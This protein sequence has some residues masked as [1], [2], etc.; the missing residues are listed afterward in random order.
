MKM[1]FSYGM[2]SACNYEI[3][4]ISYSMKFEATYEIISGMISW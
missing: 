4:E 2:I 3:I 1:A